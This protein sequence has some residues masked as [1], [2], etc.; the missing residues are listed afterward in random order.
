MRW[1]NVH[2]QRPG[3]NVVIYIYLLSRID[4][5]FSGYLEGELSRV[6]KGDLKGAL[7][8]ASMGHRMH[9]ELTRLDVLKAFE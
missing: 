8:N 3:K 1:R 9:G 4:L 5:T 7:S 2:V 6:Q